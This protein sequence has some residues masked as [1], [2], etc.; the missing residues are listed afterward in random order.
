MHRAPLK[1]LHTSVLDRSCI[2]SESQLYPFKIDTQK[3][4]E[5]MQNLRGRTNVGFAL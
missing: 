2:P 1:I 5:F 4:A 3:I